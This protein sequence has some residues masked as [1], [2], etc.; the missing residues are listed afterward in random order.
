MRGCSCKHGAPRQGPARGGW[1][2]FRTRAI[3]AAPFGQPHDPAP[4]GVFALLPPLFG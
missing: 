4:V 3:T 2:A 1:Q